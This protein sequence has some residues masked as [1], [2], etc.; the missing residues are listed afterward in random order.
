MIANSIH[1]YLWNLQWGLLFENQ[2]WDGFTLENYAENI[3]NCRALCCFLNCRK[4]LLSKSIL[5]V[6]RESYAFFLFVRPVYADVY[7]RG[8]KRSRVR[9]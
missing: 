9:H 6:I 1:V 5:S 2:K 3:K 7:D 4:K 8:A